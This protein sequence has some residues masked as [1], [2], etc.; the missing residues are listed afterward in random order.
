MWDLIIDIFVDAVFDTIKLIPFLFLTYLVMEW[1]EHKTGSRTQAT[2]RKAG[3]AGPL[4]GGII[5][6]F[7][8]CGFSAAA[9]NLFAGGLITA[10][11]LAAVF[12]STSDEMLPIFISEAVSPAT[13]VKVLVTKM[14]LAIISGFVLD[15][16]YHKLIRK[17]I[18]YKN[19][20][21]MCESEHCKCEE[22][23]LVSTIRHTLHITLFIFL[24]TLALNLIIEGVGEEQLASLVQNV[25]VVGELVAGLV[26]L[27]PN[28]AA[29]V[30]I[31]EL[32]VQGVIGSGPMMA[33]L[34]SSAGV[35]LLILFRINKKHP[36]QNLGILAYVYVVAVAWGILIDLLGI[37]F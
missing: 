16:L 13:I 15:F 22:G 6:V 33:G 27:I 8:Q 30:V 31:T 19:I 11:T 21:T 29:S 9:A 20:H 32:Y 36:K 25:P 37:R 12:L 3:K 34:L 2:I 14:V 28:C 24:I 4:F 7:P 18:R 5:G 35:G 10:G 17:E 23:I 1:L 26:G